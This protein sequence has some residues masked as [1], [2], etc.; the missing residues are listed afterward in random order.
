MWICDAYSYIAYSEHSIEFVTTAALWLSSD[1]ANDND[2]AIMMTVNTAIKCFP[3]F[4]EN[5]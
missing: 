4:V 5:L 1:R 3:L 2:P